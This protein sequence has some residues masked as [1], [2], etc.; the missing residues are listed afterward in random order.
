MPALVAHLRRIFETVFD[1]KERGLHPLE[2][3][4]AV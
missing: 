3:D 1:E 2:M 4:Q